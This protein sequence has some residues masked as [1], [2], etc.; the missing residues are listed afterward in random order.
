[1]SF[2]D[3]LKEARIAKGLKQSELSLKIGLSKGAVSNYEVG[4]SFPT[5]ET[6]YKLFEILEVDPNF[7]FQDEIGN[8]KSNKSFL[9]IKERNLIENY[10][11]LDEHGKELVD[12]IV[13]LEL[14]KLNTI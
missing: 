14:K 9:S 1:M 3:R 13:N 7:L 2:G 8:N 6:L 4:I 5:I 11:R 12:T 10:N